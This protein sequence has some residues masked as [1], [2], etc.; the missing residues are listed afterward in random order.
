MVTTADSLQFQD[1]SQADK[2]LDQRGTPFWEAMR[3]GKQLENH[4]IYTQAID[5]MGKRRAPNQGVPER[6]DVKAFEGGNSTSLNARAKRFWREPAVSTEQ[7]E[8]NNSASQTLKDYQAQVRQKIIEERRDIDF[9]ILSDVE[10]AEDDGVRGYLLRGAGRWI[11]DGTKGNNTSTAFEPDGTTR[12]IAFED[13]PTAIPTNLRTPSSQIFDG[14]IADFSE[15]TLT[16]MMEA[17]HR[18][19]GASQNFTF[20]V[21]YGLKRHIGSFGRYVPNKTGY[22][23]IERTN[24]ADIDKRRV[25]LQGIDV[26]EGDFGTFTVELEPWMPTTQRGYGMD[27]SEVQKRVRYLLRHKPQEDKGGGKRGIIDSILSAWFGDPRK[28]FKV[29][30]NT[31]EDAIVDLEA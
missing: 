11:N 1:L 31:E 6:Q 17:R 28:H 5:S 22:T 10:S 3:N 7:E 29:C 19:S 15:E 23:A 14:D 9:T 25:M 24:R 30:P 26:F 18:I 2:V 16:D 21:A 12:T 13:Q 8:F 4:K 20:W 27:M